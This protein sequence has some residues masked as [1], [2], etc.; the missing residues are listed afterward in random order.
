MPAQSLS[1][2]RMWLLLGAAFVTFSVAAG[3]MH[4]YT[5]FLVAFVEAFAWSRADVSIAYSVSQ[6]V[7]GLSSPF[8]GTLV[9][10][11]GPRRMILGGGILL[12][13]GLVASSYAGSLWHMWV[14]YGVVMTLGANCLGLVVFV[15]MLSRMFVRNRGLAVS[16][17]QSANGFARAFSAPLATM[18]VV[19]VGWRDAYWRNPDC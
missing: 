3:F 12:T 11:F 10:R 15:P 13:V 9:D 19:A 18:L 7:G 6:V 5:V 8:V 1:P 16:I 14:L 4:S 2:L 17:V